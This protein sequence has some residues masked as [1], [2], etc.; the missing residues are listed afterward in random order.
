MCILLLRMFSE[1][2]RFN[3]NEMYFDV[4]F[5]WPKKNNNKIRVYHN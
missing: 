4:Y 3:A 1:G 5:Y 2:N